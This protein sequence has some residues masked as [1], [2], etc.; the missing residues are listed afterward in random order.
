MSKESNGTKSDI[1][2]IRE[3]L[4]RIEGTIQTS[5][6]RITALER[7]RAYGAGAVA[8]LTLLVLPIV[9]TYI[10]NVMASW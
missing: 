5:E 1:R 2:W 3:T 10:T 7:W 9:L 4:V 8:V 6:E